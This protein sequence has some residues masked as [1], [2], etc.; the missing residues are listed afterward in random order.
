MPAFLL[1]A[2]G[3][4]VA[5]PDLVDTSLSVSHVAT[6][7]GAG[8][9]QITTAIV[10]VDDDTMLGVNRL[11]GKIRRIDLVEGSVVMPGPVVH[12]LDIIAPKIG[13]SQTE[14]GVQAMTLHPS[15]EENGYVYLRYDQS[16]TPGRDTPQEEVA[17][18]PNF[19][20]SDPTENVIERYVWDPRGNG[21]AGALVFDAAIY[22]ITFDTRYHHGGPIVFDNEGRLLTAIGELRHQPFVDGNFGPLLTMNIFDGIP[23]DAGVVL[24]LEDDGGIPDDNPFDPADPDTPDEAGAWYAYGVRNNFGL[25]VDPLTGLLWHTDNGESEWDEINLLAPGANGGWI[26]IMGPENHDNQTGDLDD[27]VEIPGSTYVDPAFS[28]AVTFGITAIHVLHGSA[29]GSSYDHLVIVGAVGHGLLWGMPLN[30]ARTGFA[31]ESVALQD[32]VDDRMNPFGDP[33]GT[34]AEEMFFG[35]GFGGLFSG[36]ITISRGADGLPY[37]LTATGDVYRIEPGCAADHDD[38]GETN[39]LDF[40]A[41][42]TDFVNGHPSADCDGNGVLNILDFICFQMT[43][44]A[45]CP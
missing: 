26:D 7:L 41:F 21:G 12:D 6:G 18:G 14:Y 20:A 13:D 32:L 39:I 34:E 17:P 25:D 9:Q 30:E 22:A 15:F 40:V 36:V 42:Q 33:V 28:W 8:P 10:F 5:Q 16:L 43:F 3:L 23:Y 31:F 44:Q 29:L 38:D 35:E 1:C 27:L 2:A 19:S 24:R 45:G 11:D 37:V 4:L